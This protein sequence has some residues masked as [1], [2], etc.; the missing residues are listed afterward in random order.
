MKKNLLIVVLGLLP[1]ISQAQDSIQTPKE[2]PFGEPG[3]TPRGVFGN[4]DRMEVKDAEGYEDFVRATA[5][6]ISKKSIRENRIYGYDLMERLKLQFGTSKFHENVKFLDQPTIANCTGFLIAPDILVT[7][8]HCVTTLEEAQEYIW[9]FDYTSEVH[10]DG[11]N[12]YIEVDP[13]NV[14]EVTEVVGAKFETE[15]DIDYAVLRLDRKSDRRPYRFR[16]SGTVANGTAI[17]TLGSPTGLPL[18]FSTNATVTDAEPTYWFKS[19]IDSF[20]GNSGGPVFDQNGF[21]EGILVR[22]AVE[23]TNDGYSGDYKYDPDCDCIKTVT[24]ENVD[25]TAGCQAHKITTIPGEILIQAVYENLYYA[26]EN[27]LHDRFQ[28]WD[29]YEWIFADS[30][31]GD[32]EPLEERAVILKDFGALEKIMKV[33]AKD[34]SD[35]QARRLIEGAAW[36]DDATSLKVL[37]DA[38]LYA[39]AGMDAEETVL[40]MSIK[41]GNP[42]VVELLLSYGANKNVKDKDGNNLLHLNAGSA[43]GNTTISELLV[44]HGVDAGEKNKFGMRPEKVAK[45]AGHKDLAKYLKRARKRKA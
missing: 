41:W 40:Q 2:Y 34:L 20:P 12:R 29:N 24:W 32:R 45:K 27:K 19:N 7:A 35:Y 17:N 11:Y 42:E 10:Y 3:S 14:Y 4:D 31:L 8:G 38:G 18:K 30:F 26:I 36:R 25:G 37:L 9:L 1:L 15:G 23:Y 28:D 22:G 16:T 43:N 13:E 39:D 44:G 5:V 21:I 33:K 6:M